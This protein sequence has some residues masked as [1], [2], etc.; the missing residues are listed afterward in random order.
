MDPIV[1]ANEAKQSRRGGR[2][3]GSSWLASS[4]APRNDGKGYAGKGKGGEHG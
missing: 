3:A 4:S 1:M 2:D